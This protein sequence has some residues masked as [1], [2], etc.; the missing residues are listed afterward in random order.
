MLSSVCIALIQAL[1]AILLIRFCVGGS[2]TTEIEDLKV[3]KMRRD[4]SR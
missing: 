2:G 3:M 4:M 1:A